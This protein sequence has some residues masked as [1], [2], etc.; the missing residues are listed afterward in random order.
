[1]DSKEDQ[2]TINN[3][4]FAFNVVLQSIVA[5]FGIIG[6]ILVLIMLRNCVPSQ[7]TKGDR[8]YTYILSI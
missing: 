1:M 6:N 2:D 7:D 3:T 5:S 4:I 8:I